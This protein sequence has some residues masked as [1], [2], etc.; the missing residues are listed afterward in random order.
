[1]DYNTQWCDDR[2]SE[3]SSVSTHLEGEHNVIGHR[4]GYVV[5]VVQVLVVRVALAC[6]SDVRPRVAV[7]VHALRGQ[8]RVG[9]G[10]RRG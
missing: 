1:M 9:S 3:P 2:A 4:I 10:Q 6:A 8:H 5:V 7:V